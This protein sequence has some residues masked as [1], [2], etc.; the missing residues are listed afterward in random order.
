VYCR[1]ARGEFVFDD[2]VEADGFV[3]AVGKVR[4][5]DG[6]RILAWVL[7]GNHYH[8]VVKTDSVPLWRS[9]LRLQSDVARSFNNRHRYLGR[10]WQS[11]YRARLIDTQDYLRQAVAYVHLN[12]ITAGIV[13]DPAEHSYC[14]HAEILGV[15]PLCLVDIGE[16]TRGFNDG[17]EGDPRN[18]YLMWIRNVAEAK[19]VDRGIRDLPWWKE[20]RNLDEITKPEQH[21]ESR[22]FDGRS[23]DDDRVKLGIEAFGSLFELHSG[24]YLVDLASILKGPELVRARVQYSVLAV[25]RYGFRSADAARLI[26]KHPTSICRWLERGQSDLR[27]DARFRN[28]VDDLDRRIS[29][30]ARMNPPAVRL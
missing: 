29:Q 10:L 3:E 4:D 25:A 17:I 7:M 1:V 9:M 8:L 15:R 18:L 16:L 14:G 11:R 24:W 20:A 5:L 12:P 28:Q 6:W 22:T 23:L 13:E 30:S 19:W 2:P 21:P 27:S 26:R